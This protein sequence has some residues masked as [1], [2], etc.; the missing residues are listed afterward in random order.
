[1]FA[2]RTQAESRRGDRASGPS[3]RSGRLPRSRAQPRG[4]D[5]ANDAEEMAARM[6]SNSTRLRGSVNINR[7][8]KGADRPGSAGHL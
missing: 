4:T 1:M 3:R 6:K 5:P 7:W 8:F 2:Q